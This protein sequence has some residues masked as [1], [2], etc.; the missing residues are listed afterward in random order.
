MGQQ[1]KIPLNHL[2]TPH[3]RTQNGCKSQSYVQYFG[4]NSSRRCRAV[5]TTYNTCCCWP[6]FV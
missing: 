6:Y 3:V 5:Y 4:V 1:Q 2:Q